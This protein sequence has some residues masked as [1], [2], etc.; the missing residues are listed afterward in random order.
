MWLLWLVLLA[1]IT[2]LIWLWETVILPFFEWFVYDFLP[3]FLAVIIAIVSFLVAFIVWA[4]TLG[5][6]YF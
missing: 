6:G 4:V 2:G 3:V 1:L 5:V